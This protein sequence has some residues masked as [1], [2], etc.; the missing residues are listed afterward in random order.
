[1][2]VWKKIPNCWRCDFFNSAQTAAVSRENAL[3]Y[4]ECTSGRVEW[5]WDNSDPFGNNSPNEN[6]TGAG[7][8]SFNL[9]FAGQYFD[10]ETG[11]HQNYF[12]DYDPAIGAYKQFDPIGLRGGINGF[13]YVG[14]N[15]VSFTDPTGEISIGGLV[16]LGTAAWLAYKYFDAVSTATQSAEAARNARLADQEDLDRV[17]AGGKS[18]PGPNSQDA[19]QKALRDT[20]EVGKVGAELEFAP[21]KKMSS[22]LKALN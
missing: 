6:P 8:F 21:L 5:Q 13:T 17:M 1:M 12:R 10:K 9:R 7:Q 11:L 3:A 14:G 22:V 16:A 2:R 19:T 15:P 18:C 20:A 4:D